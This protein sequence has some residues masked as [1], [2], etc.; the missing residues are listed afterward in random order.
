LIPGLIILRKTNFSEL[1][2]R[3]FLVFAGA[4]LFAMTVIHLIP[5]L[6][7]SGENP[8]NLGLYILIGFFLQKVLENFSNGI[9]HGHLHLHSHSHSKVPVTYLLI[10]LVI[11]SFL[12]GSILTD[13]L[14]SNHLSLSENDYGSSPKILLGIVMHKIPAS[15][16]LTALLVTQLKSKMKAFFL[17]LIFAVSS[18]LGLISSEFFSHSNLLSPEY[19][20]IFFAIVAGSFLQISTTIFIESDPNHKLDW[21]RFSISLLGAGAAV[22][23]Q[24]TF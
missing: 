18:P 12:E 14:H 2:V 16:A 15:L 23:A 24:L 9:E 5:D 11:H 17:L 20:V 21:R 22:L 1:K 4:Y 13:S 8:F 7:L 6:F 3:Y 10:A 19:M